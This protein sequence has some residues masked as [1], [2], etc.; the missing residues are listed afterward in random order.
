MQNIIIVESPSKSKTIGSYVGKGYLVLSSKG[1][2]CDLA[3][4]GKDGLGID[5]EHDFKPNY[6][7]MK[8]KEEL[9]EYLKTTCKGR[10]VYLAT[11]P[12]REGEA[13]AYHLARELELSLDDLNRIEFNEI[14]KP[15]VRKALENP[16]KIDMQMVSSQ[17]C[18]RMIDRI[19]GFK[20]SKL[21]QR[22]IG[23]KSAGRVQSVVLKLIVDLEKEILA[24]VP[25]PYYEMEANFNTF[26][27]KL[28]ELDGNPVD[29]KNRILDRKIL[30]NLQPKLMSFFVSNIA[31]KL[32][33]RNSYPAFTTSTLQQDAANKLNFPPSKTMRIAQG[34][35][36]GKTIKDETV[37]L[38]TYMRTDS[39]RLSDL[40]V[41]DA[42]Q[43]I[44]KTY[45]DKYLGDVKIKTSKNMQ[46]AHEA[47]RPTAVERTPDQMKPYLSEEEYELYR[48]IYN[49]TM[50]S[51]MAPA[52]FN[53]LRVEF[54]NTNSLWAVTGQTMEFDGYLR[55]Y[56]R[57]EADENTIL[58]NFSLGE[59]Y[60]ANEIVILDKKTAPKARYTDASIIK[61]MET[62][63]IGRPSTYAQTILTLKER[64]YITVDKKSL[65]P[66]EQGTLTSEK[67]D[68][69]FKDLINVS[70]TAEMETN[71]D[72]IAHG[73]KKELEQLKEFYQ[74]FIPL[75]DVAMEKM[76]PIYP[77]PTE[78]ICP[79]CG[80]ML[81]IRK[82]KFG[83][84]ISCSNYP[85]CKYVYKEE[86]ENEPI[87]T[88]IVCT[89]CGKGHIV[90]R[91]AKTGKNK[92]GVFYACNNYPACKVAFSDPPTLLTCPNCGSIMLEDKEGHLYCS[93]QCD[94][95]EEPA[96]GITCPVC[97]KGHMVKRV[98]SKGKNKGNIFYG[99]SNYPRCKNIMTEED[100]QNI[101]G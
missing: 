14:T 72:E 99:C 97:K 70:Y 24:F 18:R 5:I 47:I 20:L 78:Q 49:R 4:S 98:A 73:T 11:D 66:T 37:G 86:T 31:H 77:I 34:L 57:S 94:K 44:R 61:E 45:G 15:A 25:T 36:E 67:L 41:T 54:T 82:S 71:L 23:S 74:A 28:V 9:V 26:K 43:Y 39:T 100:V 2:I 88:G 58:P 51:L 7:V 79:E 16:H 46:D 19:L 92:G 75:F 8:D 52:R 29:N 22:K 3:T 68:M 64:N 12:D 10:Q 89:E 63:G 101:S 42:H 85:T 6:K 93:K 48:L 95:Q 53:S 90:E 65:V 38:I 96:N 80:G 27:L 59:G 91:I 87:D 13:I 32:V 76:K 81:V 1:H 69:F 17:E 33:N 84:F 40:F 21:L 30:E 35:Y 55:A 83:E 60:N 62:L 56:G 50:A